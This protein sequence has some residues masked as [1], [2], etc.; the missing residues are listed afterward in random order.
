MI[1]VAGPGGAGKTTV[2]SSLAARLGTAFVDLDEQFTAAAGDISAYLAAHGYKAYAGRNIQVCL[3][4]M[5]VLR[6]E[7]VIALSSG[8]MTYPD[9]A[10]PSYRRLRQGIIDSPATVVLLPSFD[11]ET[12]V[13]E[14]VSRQL[15]R[16]FSRSA[17]REEQVIRVR[18]SVYCDLSV[19]KFETNG[20]VDALVDDLVAHLLPNI[21]LQPTAAGAIMS[22]RG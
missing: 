13:A 3:D 6:E 14:T 5:G 15:R 19:A 20:P 7:G 10:H 1:Q 21:R 16:P 11:Y 22:H 12:C 9:D 4:S 17:D 18:F 8:F 2:G